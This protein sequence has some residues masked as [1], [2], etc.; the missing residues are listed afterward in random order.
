MRAVALPNDLTADN[1][2]TGC[3][4]RL[5]HLDELTADL[6]KSL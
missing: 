3:T 1:D 4:R 2:F 6:L 5:V